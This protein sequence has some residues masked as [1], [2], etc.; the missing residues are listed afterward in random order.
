VSGASSDLIEL[1]PTW[2]VGD[3]PHGGYLLRLLAAAA[4]DES[5]PHPFAVSAHYLAS[6]TGGPADVTVERLRT[7]RRVTSSRVR[8]EQDGVHRVEVLVTA[9]RHEAAPEP[10]WTAPGSAPPELPAWADCP[11]APAVRAD[12][13]PIGFLDHVDMRLDPATAG[14]A[15]GSPSGAGVVRGWLGRAD[16]ADVTALDLLVL[17][18]ALP[19]VTFDL[20]MYGWVPTVELTVLV[21]GLPAPGPLR[22]EQRSS[23]LADGWLDED[24]LLWDSTGRLVAQARQLAGYRLPS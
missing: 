24:C 6:P 14:Y 23:L 18:D 9:G 15:S 1:D 12:G 8:L 5:H 4:V 13:V 11:R 2:A 21:R 3:R 20:G 16:G 17:A 22:A 19:P 7:G 10:Y